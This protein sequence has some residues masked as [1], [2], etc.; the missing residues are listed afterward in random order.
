MRQKNSKEL[1]QHG[2]LRR[3]FKRRVRCVM[4]VEPIILFIILFGVHF[5][6]S[7]LHIVLSNFNFHQI[8]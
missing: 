8:Y 5:H 7:V 1:A 6:A 4:G 3:A 2:E